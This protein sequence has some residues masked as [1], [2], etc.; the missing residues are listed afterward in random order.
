ML[1]QFRR[2]VI[3]TSVAVASAGFLV[4]GP[5]HAVAA[6][7][8]A[9][10][11]RGENLSDR[12]VTATAQ[13]RPAR[14][15]ATPRGRRGPRGPRGLRGPQGPAGERGPAGEAGPPGPTGPAGP[16]GPTGPAGPPG[17]KGDPCPPS[18]NA[19]RG[20]SGPAGP[21]GPSASFSEVVGPTRQ[22]EPASSD[23]EILRCGPNALAISGGLTTS[24]AEVHLSQSY[25]SRS[26]EW[27]FEVFNH[28][29]TASWTPRLVCAAI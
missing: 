2:V 5:S 29:P 3:L 10:G 26:D 28:G 23:L 20:P 22:V 24:H 15:A 17:P 13:E 16:P 19:C 8:T 9:A 27:T 1:A 21:P 12:S 4:S 25:R 11:G 7:V 6:S 14:Q 18:E